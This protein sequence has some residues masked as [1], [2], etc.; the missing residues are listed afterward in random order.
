MNT[1][2]TWLP[3]QLCSTLRVVAQLHVNQIA[4]RV[5]ALGQLVDV[6]DVKASEREI[7]RLTRGL[8]AWTVTQISDIADADA[9]IAVTD[10]YGDNGIDAI[11]IDKA[12]STIYIVQSKW[13]RTGSSGI[14]QGDALKFANGVRDLLNSDFGKFNEKVR[15]RTAE[16]EA[17]IADPQLRYV[18]V[19][20]TTGAPAPSRHVTD[21]LSALTDELNEPIPT[22]SF[23]HFGQVDLHGLLVSGVKGARPDLADVALHNYA[24]KHEPYRAHY[25]QVA[26]ADLAAWHN[27]HG[28][29]LYAQNLRQFLGEDSSVNAS[30]LETLNNDPALFWY[31]NNGVTVLCQTIAAS[32]KG[33]TGKALGYFTLTGVSVVNGAQTVGTI[34]KAAADGVPLEDV[35]VTVRF[36]SLEDC[37]PDFAT[38]VTRGTNTQN[39]VERRDFVALDPQQERLADEMAIDGRR[40]VIKSGE[41]VPPPTIGCTVIEATIA[42][43]CAKPVPDFA[44]QA[45]RE[46][47]RLWTGA[48][49]PGSK[50]QYRQLFTP[51]LTSEHLWRAVNVLRAIDSA[52]EAEQ[53]KRTDKAKALGT[54][55]NRLIA[56]E[57]FQR[58]PKGV[59][60]DPAVDMADQ[61]A[62]VARHVSDVYGETETIVNQAYATKYLASLFK[63]AGHCKAI[64]NQLAGNRP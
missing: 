20:T 48:E 28:D 47:G 19:L 15:K 23:R 46:I 27:A 35:W 58:L 2:D 12:N 40:Y 32:K 5:G 3:P 36:I 63:N 64:V 8:A 26:G 59:L 25:G 11:A 4:K 62:K 51:D 24:S 41:A 1:L 16:L 44:V 55:A 54:H 57:V 42:L 56:H 45:K 31:L 9:A 13:D 37:P 61:L 38:E 21:A 60:I 50:G 14:A 10:G 30:L 29:R 6:G 49:D 52:I 53:G 34:G 22:A 33:G 43:A 17:A 7:A 18:L 39:R